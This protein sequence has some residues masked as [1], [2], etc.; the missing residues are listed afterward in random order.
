MSLDVALILFQIVAL[1]FALSVHECAHA[2]VAWR[3][4]DPTA[5]MLGRVT[6]NP[7]K[8]L[9]P[10]GSVLFPVIGMFSGLPFIGWAKPCP[11]TTRNF[12]KVKRDDILTTLAGPG[13]N[14]ALAL[15]ALL[16]LII[17]RHFVRGGEVA[18]E[19]ALGLAFHFQGID[20]TALP[21]LF[22]IALL[23]FY[24][25]LVDLTLFVF[26]FI[27]IPPLDGSR[28]LRIYLPYNALRFYDSMGMFSLIILMLVGGRLLGVFFMPLLSLFNHAL[29]TI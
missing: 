20:T 11:I 6:L 17:L 27:P 13:S 5:K 26:N 10:I 12:K 9:D 24:I 7:L 29:L 1:F 25:L 2:Y 19:T 14:L 28:I 18:V 15:I 4:G 21:A 22:P 16:L 23:L 3:L 8:H